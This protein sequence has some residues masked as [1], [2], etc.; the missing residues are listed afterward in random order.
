M[1]RLRVLPLFYVLL[2]VLALAGAGLSGWYV[3]A[4]AKPM[5]L[6]V[7]VGGKGG[8]I[9][10]L[11]EEVATLVQSQSRAIRIEVV[12]T[13]GSATN[14]LLVADGG[15][16][17]ASVQ[18]DILT[19]P[20]VRL[21]A[22]IAR[23]HFQLFARKSAGIASLRDLTGRRLALPPEGTSGNANFFA[24]AAH[25]DLPLD[26]MS[27]R[28]GPV[29][30]NL[31]ALERGEVDAVAFVRAL[32]DPA[33]LETMQ[34]LQARGDG[35]TFI[36]VPQAA[37]LR[38]VKPYVGEGLIAEGT[39]QGY[40]PVPAADVPTIAIGIN[41][42]AGERVPAYA[43][44]EL[45]RILFEEQLRL[46][47]RTPLGA[48]IARPARNGPSLPLH[49]GAQSYYDGTKPF[50]LMRFREEIT[51]G[52]SMLTLIYSALMMVRMRVRG[53]RKVRVS[54]YNAELMRISALAQ[55]SPSLTELR[56]CRADLNALIHR[57]MKDFAQERISDQGFQVFSLT[58]EAVRASLAEAIAEAKLTEARGEGPQL[59][60]VG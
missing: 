45:T 56:A 51:F 42:V 50:I 7:A 13:D 12:P 21:V 55:S 33:T 41:L 37:A 29:N 58:W 20:N 31:A 40:P 28:S 30:D 3:L 18:A 60:A 15:V 25:H 53:R 49:A 27:I 35:L 44:E 16:E 8:N 46:A 19:A 9:D 1:H 4:D 59:R 6:R 10:K 14:A 48:D 43:I 52:I 24:M 32:R 54:A 57:V 17:L 39:Y 38:L 26:R 23:E 36:P 47:F 34:R 5:T 22:T 2:G 11:M